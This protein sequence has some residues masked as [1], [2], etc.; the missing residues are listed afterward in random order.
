[1]WWKLGGLA[2][3]SA[4]LIAL[5]FLPLGGAAS[6]KLD[7]PP[8]AAPIASHQIETGVGLVQAWVA[9]SFVAVVLGAAY[10]LG[11]RIVRRHRKPD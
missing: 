3:L 6:V 10:W 1:M 9:A 11:V 7:M 4:G 5:L 8:G 2:V